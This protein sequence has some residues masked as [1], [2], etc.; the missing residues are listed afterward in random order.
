MRSIRINKHQVSFRNKVYLESLAG[1]W[2][3]LPSDVPGEPETAPDAVRGPRRAGRLLRDPN[4]T[5]YSKH[6]TV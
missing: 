5:Q 4:M 2:P 1:N 6:V 3:L